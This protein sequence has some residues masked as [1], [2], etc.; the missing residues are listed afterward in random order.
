MIPAGAKNSSAKG[1]ARYTYVTEKGNSRVSQS[2]VSIL[3]ADLES[4]FDSLSK[5]Y[6]I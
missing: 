2:D 4:A 1:N 3:Q 6:L 5:P